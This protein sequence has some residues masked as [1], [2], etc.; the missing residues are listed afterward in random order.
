MSQTGMFPPY[1]F[2]EKPK[3]F[4]GCVCICRATQRNSGSS[5]WNAVFRKAPRTKSRRTARKMMADVCDIPGPLEL[6]GSDEGSR[7]LSK[8]EKVVIA[9]FGFVLTLGIALGAVNRA[10]I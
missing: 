8:L 7:L 9:G 4:P 6:A 1:Q 10:Q 2:T 3:G 5:M